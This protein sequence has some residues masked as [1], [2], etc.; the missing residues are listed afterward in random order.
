MPCHIKCEYLWCMLGF[1]FNVEFMLQ[2]I[3]VFFVNATFFNCF[4]CKTG[5][6]INNEKFLENNC[7]SL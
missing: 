6:H 4:V 3:L 5:W 7:R 2:K 1:G